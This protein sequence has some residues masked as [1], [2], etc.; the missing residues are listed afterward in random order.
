[1]NNQLSEG[2]S[3]QHLFSELERFKTASKEVEKRIVEVCSQ[4]KAERDTL[5]AERDDLKEQLDA[6]RKKNGIYNHNLFA[7]RFKI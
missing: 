7:L 2:C 5:K 3:P 6:L 1:M 4:L